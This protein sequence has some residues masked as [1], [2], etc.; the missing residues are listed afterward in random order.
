M[1]VTFVLR[2]WLRH[3]Y[4]VVVEGMVL[5]GKGKSGGRGTCGGGAGRDDATD[6]IHLTFILLQ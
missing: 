2:M 6:S 4:L 5:H 3:R 1:M